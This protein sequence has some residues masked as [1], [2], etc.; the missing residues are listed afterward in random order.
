MIK[1]GYKI[2][3]RTVNNKK[4]TFKASHSALL[5]VLALDIVLNQLEGKK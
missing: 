4:F 3:K 2:I 5:K 1:T